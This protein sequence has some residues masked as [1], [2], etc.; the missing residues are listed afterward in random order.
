MVASQQVGKFH[1][2]PIAVKM[3]GQRTFA[4]A[5]VVYLYLIAD[6]LAQAAFYL[7]GQRLTQNRRLFGLR[8]L[9]QLFAECFGLAHIQIAADDLAGS[10]LHQL[11]GRQAQD[12]LCMADADRT[13]AQIFQHGARKGQ[14]AQHIGQCAAAFAQLFG[15][16]LL[17][18][19]AL[20]HQAFNAHGLFYRVKIFP[21]QVFYQRQLHGLFIGH[22][23]DHHRHLSQA[24]NAAGTPAA[25]ARNDDIAGAGGVLPHRDG[26]QQAVFD[27]APG[28]L[29]QRFGLKAFA[30]LFRVRLDLAQGQC[31]DLARLLA[32]HGCTVFKKAVQPAAKTSFGFCH[33]S[34]SFPLSARY[35]SKAPV[36]FPYRLRCLC[37]WA[38]NS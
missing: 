32:A 21:L 38:R 3:Q 27:N 33:C 1:Q 30:R 8:A 24:G 17:C 25:L 9:C 7:Y 12:H 23:L 28:Q 5:L 16:L 35:S 36:P 37:R 20:F 34:T 6:H 13:H 31:G 18:K 29:C 4:A 11:W 26:L 14:Q 2:L 19:A 10:L 22:I 15:S